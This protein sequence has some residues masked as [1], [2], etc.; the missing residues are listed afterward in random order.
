M[1]LR[2][3][4]DSPAGKAAC[5]RR[6]FATIADRYDLITVVLSFGLDRRWK[7]RLIRQARPLAGRRVLDLAAGTGDL[8][9]L[10][11][12]EGARVVG[13]DVTPRMIQLARARADGRGGSGA[14]F[15]VGDM[16]H[17]P[18]AAGAFDVVTTGYGLRNVPELDGALAEI[19]R[20]L[21]PGGQLLSL[22]FDLPSSPLVRRA[23]LAWLR[24]FGGALGWLLH[25]D[26]ETYRYIPETLRRYPGARGV[27]G[28]LDRTGFQ[29][30]R[31][32]P[33]L[34]GLLAIHIAQRS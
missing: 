25:R 29:D 34:G 3:S 19:H 10:A 8:A 16:M 32:L 1:S 15:L 21:A 5:T 22:D 7:Q 33:V 24:L 9:F 20:V 2:E 23:Y 26:P 14:A 18:F 6:T 27:C 28:Q 4:L 17:L 11:A 31:W 12:D 13:L 30:I